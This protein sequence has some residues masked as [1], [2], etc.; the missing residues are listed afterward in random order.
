MRYNSNF[1]APTAPNG[2]LMKRASVHKYE[3]C[4]A[5]REYLAEAECRAGAVGIPTDDFICNKR[6]PE[7]QEQKEHRDCGADGSAGAGCGGAR[8][9]AAYRTLPITRALRCCVYVPDGDADPEGRARGI[10]L[11]TPTPKSPSHGN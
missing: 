6:K 7:I 4:L 10:L 3:R 8:A 9:L 2:C 11:S 1:H 5:L